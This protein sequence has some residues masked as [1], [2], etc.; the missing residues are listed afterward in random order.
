[1]KNNYAAQCQ[2][3]AIADSVDFLGFLDQKSIFKKADQS[4]LFIHPSQMGTDK[5]Q[6]GVPNAML[7]TMTTGLPPITTRHGG[8]PEA[9]T[10]EKSGML[11]EEGDVKN[12]TE[13][14]LALVADPTLY[15]KVSEGARQA[16]E[17]KFEFR[18][19]ITRLES[20]YREAIEAT[21]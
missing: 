1:M 13:N 8:I 19:Q 17:E 2:K 15:K 5:N 3:L 14:A 7:E 4:H 12:L 20:H 21:K 18:S 6:E 11:S 16:I 9:V 10:H